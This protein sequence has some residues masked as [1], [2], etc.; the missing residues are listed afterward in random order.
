[1]IIVQRRLAADDP[2]GRMVAGGKDWEPGLGV[3]WDVI[4][5]PAIQDAMGN[6]VDE[7]KHP[8]WARPLWPSVC[9][10]GGHGQAMEFYTQRRQMLGERTFSALYQG[11]IA[12]MDSK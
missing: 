6:P 5:L 8:T 9:H 11:V 4:N 3:R 2:Y 10:Q 7:R 1:M 12:D